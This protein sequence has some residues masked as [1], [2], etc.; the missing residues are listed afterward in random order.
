MLLAFSAYVLF[1]VAF[2]L[3][4]PAGYVFLKTENT[5]RDMFVYSDPFVLGT[6]PKRQ[7]ALLILEAERMLNRACQIGKAWILRCQQCFLT[8]RTFCPYPTQ[9][10]CLSARGASINDYELLW[11]FLPNEEGLLNEIWT[12]PSMNPNNMTNIN[13]IPLGVRWI[14][15]N[16]YPQAVFGIFAYEK[17]SGGG[18]D[19]CAV[20]DVVVNP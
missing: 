14:I 1:V 20:T 19:P 10:F 17:P 8:G 5:I 13:Q 16:Q 3:I 4:F 2:V 12:A 7:R 18:V 15:Q 6:K 9:S 11:G